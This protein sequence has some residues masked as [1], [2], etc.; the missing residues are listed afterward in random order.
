MIQIENQTVSGIPFLHIVKEENS[1]RAVPLVFFI[2][3]FTSAKEHNLHFAY[4]LAQKG[5]RAVLPEALFHGERGENMTGEELAGHF[6][7]IVLNEIE[8]L[9][10]LK[11]YFEERD[12]IDDGRIGLAGTSMGGIT[13]LGAMTA[14]D[15]VKAGVSLMGSPNYVE[16]FQQ[17]IEHIKSQG[18]NID[19]PQERVDD[20]IERL[21]TRDLSLQPDSLRHR[22]LLFWHGVKD[23]VVPYAP[24]RK[25][26]D[27][28]KPL[29][30]EQPELLQFIADE[31]ADHKV[32][33]EALLKT[34]AWFETHL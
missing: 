5:F 3:G 12:L 28:I 7:D 27:T 21:K 4:L 24:T 9:N 22:P 34:V 14:Y 23:K 16:L 8:E 26:Y 17:Q 31:K 19:V 6:W 11:T 2:H 1:R 10:V 32:S 25:F 29:Y 18:I 15:W 13:T 33:R 30:S 20:L